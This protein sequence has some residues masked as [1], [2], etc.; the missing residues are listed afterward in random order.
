[1]ILGIDVSFYQD[2]NKTPNK[3][4]FAKAKKAGAEFC[5]VRVGQGSYIDEDFSYNWQASKDAGLLRGGYWFY[6][7]REKYNPGLSYQADLFL[8]ALKGDYGELGLVMD[9]EKPNKYYPALP[10]RE[11]SLEIIFNFT[12]L[13]EN[14][15][16]EETIFYSNPDTLKNVLKVNPNDSWLLKK[17]LWL[18]NY[19]KTPANVYPWSKWDFWQFTDRLDGLAF[20]VESRMVDGDYFNGS[21]EELKN[22]RKRNQ[23]TD[24][25]KLD[26]LWDWY[27]QNT[28]H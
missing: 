22:Y 7:Y 13:I 23:F 11:K 8:E 17:P 9:Y 24:K 26:Y 21:L 15:T 14:E 6:E 5:F 4:D 25:Q 3:I 12:S 19:S 18:A 16:Q 2:D 27:L 20:G 1:M 10:P 28:A